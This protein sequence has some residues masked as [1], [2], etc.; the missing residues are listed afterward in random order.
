ME[1]QKS[2]TEV[3]LRKLSERSCSREALTLIPGWVEW[4]EGMVPNTTTEISLRLAGFRSW[5][6]P[7]G[8]KA[9]QGILIVHPREA[10]G[11]FPLWV[12]GGQDMLW[13]ARCGAEAGLTS[14]IICHLEPQ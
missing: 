10:R 13:R 11:C 2:V 14:G 6:S 12:P 4:L 1:P 7:L 8:P 5:N 3:I 9:G